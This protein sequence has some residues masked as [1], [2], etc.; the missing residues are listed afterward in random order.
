VE[1]DFWVEK[2]GKGVLVVKALAPDTDMTNLDARM[3]DAYAVMA[4]NFL[5][6]G[7]LPSGPNRVLILPDEIS[8]VLPHQQYLTYHHVFERLSCEIIR[9]PAIRELEL[10][11]EEEEREWNQVSW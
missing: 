4:L 9:K 2:E 1:P 10:Y 7:M 5:T 11:R 6:H 8:M 3:R